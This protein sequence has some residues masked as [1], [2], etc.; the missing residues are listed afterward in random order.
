MVVRLRPEPDAALDA[1]ARELGLDRSS[2][3]RFLVMEKARALGLPVR[4]DADDER[5]AAAPPASPPVSPP[6]PLPARRARR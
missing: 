1:I 5:R 4:A 6:M 3:I 2:T